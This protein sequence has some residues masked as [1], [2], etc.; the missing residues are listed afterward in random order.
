ME[1]AVKRAIKLLRELCDECLESLIKE[2]I[3]N[4]Q[5]LNK[6]FKHG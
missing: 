6:D 1:K 4:Q 3:H 5:H 2:K